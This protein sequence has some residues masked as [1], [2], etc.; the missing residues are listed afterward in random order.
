MDVEERYSDYTTDSVLE[1][2]NITEPAI[3]YTDYLTMNQTNGTSGDLMDYY[4]N[5][6]FDDVDN[7]APETG[8]DNSETGTRSWDIPL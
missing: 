4:G 6:G 1:T 5:Q 8:S 2:S 3:N 7:L